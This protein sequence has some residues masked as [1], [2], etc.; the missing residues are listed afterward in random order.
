M[1]RTGT[2]PGRILWT[3]LA[4]LTLLTGCE[5][6]PWLPFAET[7]RRTAGATASSSTT[8][9]AT[10]RN[11]SSEVILSRTFTDGAAVTSATYQ[12]GDLSRTPRVIDFNGDGKADAVVGYGG[13]T[14]V[15]QILLSDGPAG[16]VR[17]RSLTFD[18]RTD[19]EGLADVAVG[20]VDG[21]GYLD[22]VV[23]TP[24]GVAY[25]RHPNP[26]ETGTLNRSTTDLRFWGEGNPEAVREI[27]VGTDETLTN[28]DLLGIITDAVGPFVNLDDYLVTVRQGYLSVEIGDMDNDG[29]N[30]V[31]AG[32]R[33]T[34]DLTPRPGLDALEPI[35]I[36][37]GVVQVLYNPGRA[38]DGTGW[39]ATSVGR[40][41]RLA[42][43][44]DRYEPKGLLLIDVDQDGD[45]DVLSTDLVDNNVQVSWF[46]NPQIAPC[47]PIALA[48][49]EWLQWRVGSVRDAFSLDVADLTGDGWLDVIATGRQQQQVILFEHPGRPFCDASSAPFEPD[50]RYEFDWDAWVIVTFEAIEPRD[51]R[52]LDI[53]NDGVLELVV[54]GNT[55]AVRYFEPPANPRLTWSPNVIVTF[56][57][58]MQ[59]GGA[60]TTVDAG[61]A[62][63][64]TPAGAGGSS[65]ATTAPEG[66]VGLLGY[67]DF[68][69]DGDLDL[70]V[71]VDAE[72]DNAERLIWIR[73]DLAIRR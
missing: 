40:H 3:V 37:N 46:Q 55:G 41:E 24:N 19:W 1:A 65:G 38:I 35:Q 11:F 48:G 26:T 28:D 6:Y 17:F 45:L 57:S 32:R 61:G 2:L 21:D 25:L 16:E 36:I 8:A 69:G 5:V 39:T 70:I 60:T 23:A 34:I 67:G 62:T 30:D 51:V 31:V 71:V 56:S 44:I 47:P 68:D 54:G 4:P 12:L 13:K 52:A 50:R 9:G 59:M 18:A 53:D 27:I 73:N 14:G 42:T 43:G 20:D 22:L 66:D 7:N 49:E 10:S 72:D 15:V 58:T 29:D 33:F 64:V 63:T